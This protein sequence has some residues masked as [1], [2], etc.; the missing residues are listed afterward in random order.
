MDGVVVDLDA[1]TDDVR[2]FAIGDVSHRPLPLYERQFRLESVPNALEQ[3]K[4]AAA[5]IVGR[6]AAKP[7]TPWFWSDQYDLKLQI[8]GLP[9]DTDQIIVRGDVVAAKFAVFHLKGD[10]V[11]AV[12]AV[13]APSEFMAGKALIG[14]RTP[15]SLEKL[16]D[17][18]VSMKDVAA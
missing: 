17:A 18:A 11:Q 4:Q 5:A 6:L 13:N 7:E 2:I 10:L 12:E 1:R 8:A 16:A 14:K 9:F 3:A 15:V